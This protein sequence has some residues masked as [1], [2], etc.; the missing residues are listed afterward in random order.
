MEKRIY[1]DNG[2]TTQVDPAVLDAMLPFFCKK[3]GNVSSLH[4]FGKEARHS[5]EKNRKVIAESINAEP[6]EIIFT[7]GGTESDNLAIK[8]IAVYM[9][10]KG[11]NHII[12]TKIEHPA[13]LNVCKVLERKGISVTYLDVDPEGFIDLKELEQKITEKTSLVSIIHANNEI[14]T[15]QDMKKIGEIC[16][17]KKVLFHTDAVQSF[18]KVPIDVKKMKIDLLSLSGHKIH[19]PKG[20]GVLYVKKDL[21]IEPLLHGGGQENGKRAGTENASGIIG[22]GKAVELASDKT[23]VKKMTRLRDYFIG[24]I[25]KEIPDTKLNGPEGSKRLCNNINMSFKYV[26]GESILLHLDNYGIAVSTGSACSQLNLRPSHVLEALDLPDEFVHGTIR[27]TISRFTTKA[28]LDYAAE[29][30]KDIIKK[31]R[32]IS[33]LAK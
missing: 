11:K 24:R 28:E 15:I 18:T 8:G 16:R 3:Y 9:R 17:K 1:L 6:E 21:S 10:D 32:K 20:T 4:S 5:V 7:S 31:L 2:A 29:K 22:F 23:H 27:F 14:G 26:E 33:P 12:T 13:V 30:L 19:G 25:E